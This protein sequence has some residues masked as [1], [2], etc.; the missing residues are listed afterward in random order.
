MH[1]ARAEQPVQ[2]PC[3]GESSSC[4]Y[5]PPSQPVR[6]P[7]SRL[8][9]HAALADKSISLPLFPHP[10][11][12]PTLAAPLSL[13]PFTPHPQV[14]RRTSHGGEVLA[15]VSNKNLIGTGGALDLFTQGLSSA[16]V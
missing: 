2:H 14:A 7:I 4:P 13:S 5:S 12:L 1:Q 10:A 9:A 16:N 3:K 11:F 15:A 6:T 8:E